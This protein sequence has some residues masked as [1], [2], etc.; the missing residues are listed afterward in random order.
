MR[1]G[2]WDALL[3]IYILNCILTWIMECIKTFIMIQTQHVYYCQ[4]P[5][6]G[7]SWESTLFSCGNNNKNN[8]TK[9]LPEGALLGFWNFACDAQLPNEWYCTLKHDIFGGALYPSFFTLNPTPFI[10][11]YAF[12]NFQSYSRGWSL[13]SK[14]SFLFLNIKPFNTLKNLNLNTIDLLYKPKPLTIVSK[15]KLIDNF[16]IHCFAVLM[17]ACGQRQ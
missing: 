13:T 15:N 2:E 1:C 12:F 14:K 8:L 5:I 9:I 6:P 4:T 11:H 16:I 17:V 10:L 7:Q 3:K